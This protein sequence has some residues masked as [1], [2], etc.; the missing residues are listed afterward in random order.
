FFDLHGVQ[1]ADDQSPAEGLIRRVKV[2]FV[3]HVG[4][5]GMIRACR[6]AREADIAI[7]ADFESNESPEFIDLLSL[8]DHLILSR[9]FAAKVT[10]LSDP[11]SAAKKL[12]DRERKTI[13]VTCGRDG[14]WYLGDNLNGEAVHQPAFGVQALDTTGCGDVFH[15]AYASGLVQ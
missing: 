12:W 2:L 6:I 4:V 1:G 13:I 14:C 11:S 5:T 8:V 10:G 9:D 3:D 15:G 7:V